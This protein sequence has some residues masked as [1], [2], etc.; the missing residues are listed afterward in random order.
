MNNFQKYK[1]NFLKS[2][3]LKQLKAQ[4]HQSGFTITGHD[5]DLQTR[6][7][8]FIRASRPMIFFS[9]LYIS[10]LVGFDSN[11]LKTNKLK[12]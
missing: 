6:F 4:M 3:S 10:L 12:K 8:K 2:L 9:L 5:F 1:L 11:I 7:S